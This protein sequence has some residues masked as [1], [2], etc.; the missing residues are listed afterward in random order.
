[1]GRQDNTAWVSEVKDIN[2]IRGIFG[3][4]FGNDSDYSTSAV[5]RFKT[6]K[7]EIGV[8]SDYGVITNRKN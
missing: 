5:L 8:C 4:Y 7:A 3:V 1:M 2:T 6:H